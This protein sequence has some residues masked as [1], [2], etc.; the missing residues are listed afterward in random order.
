MNTRFPLFLLLVLSLKLANAATYYVDASVGNDTWSGNQA[1]PLGS[2]STDGP[3]QS[4]AKVSAGILAPGDSVLL[5]CGEIWNET[6]TLQSSGTAVSPIAI[7]AYP[8]ACTNKP[9]IS[10]ST[11]IPAHNW[12]QD[13]G[14]IYK[15]SSAIDLITFG[16]FESGLG[17]WA[18]WSPNNN[19]IMNLSTSCAS[20]GNTCMSFTA[21]SGNSIVSSNNFTLYGKQS[22]TA[23]FTWKFPAGIPIRVILRR[24]A[25]PWNT[26]GLDTYITGTGTWQTLTVPFIA[27]AGL[28]NAR[29]DFE[30]PAGRNISLDNVKISAVLADVAGVFDS[31]KAISVAHHPNRGY[32]PLKSDSL[33]YAIAEDADKVNLTYGVIGSTYL[34][35]GADLSATVHPAITAGT[36]IRVRTN[37]WNISDRKI[38]S[39][40]GSRFYFDSPTTYTVEKD[41]GYF[42]YGQRWMLD[43]PGEWHYDAATKTVYVWMPDSAAPGTRVVVGQRATGIEASNLSHIRI[44]GL[45]IQHVGTGVLMPDAINIVLSNMSISDTLGTGIDAVRSTDSGVESSQ[46][47]RTTGDA[48][49]AAKAD[50]SSIRFHA[51]DNL[52]MDS[53]SQ[54]KNGIITSLPVPARAAIEAGSDADIRGNSIYGTGYIGIRPLGSSLVSGNHI[55]NA[56]LILDDCGAIYTAGQNNN[57]IIEN[58]TVLHVP[59]GLPGRPANQSSQSQGIYLDSLCAGV[60]IRGNTV[61]DADSGIQL[62]SATNNHIENNT[63]YGNRRHQI[64]MHEGTTLVDAEG[65]MSG[66]HVLGNRLFSTLATTAIG[67][68][69]DLPKDN[70][71][72]FSSYDGNQF[73]TLLSPTMSSETWP[74]GGSDYT[75]PEWQTAVTDTGLPRNL[76]PTGSEV[77]SASIGYAAFRTAGINIVPNGNLGSGKAGWTAWN[78]TAPYGQ[79][80]LEPCTP[81]S[82]CLSYTAGASE[83]LVSS[84]NFSVQKDQWYKVSFDLKTG[85]NGQS[86]LV[87]A[88]RGGG[89]SNGYE[90]LMGAAI[91]FTGSVSWQR[92][93]FI[94]KATKTINANDPVTLDLG[95]R[96]DFTRILSGQDFSVANL[97]AVPIS[98]VE[99]TFRSHIL[100]NPTDTN[101]A[102]NCPDGSDAV[103]CSEYVR[104]TDSQIVT[105]PYDLPPH[106]SEIIYSRDI[107]LI[108]G[109][110]DG[111]PDYQDSC[112]GTGVLQAVN[113]IG[114]TL[115]QH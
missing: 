45:A 81:A 30:V 79:I 83:G 17:N 53:S 106:G 85:T 44:E 104:F 67:H 5:K 55:E 50:S 2:P 75:L 97:E 111:I 54:T 112:S 36:G 40:S 109:D 73:F 32:D 47:I 37:A 93:G 31:G 48:I 82:Q 43:E 78:L 108:D 57:S 19:A 69:T 72:R 74:G 62:Y 51:Y 88:R 52:I 34:T 114:C 113:A 86:V 80:V 103:L 96:I 12:I 15:L 21:G 26:V 8:Y 107:N 6:L 14:N 49:S 39:V 110:G 29:L 71:D 101:L 42:L 98:S 46:I 63:L 27:T 9:L 92:Y 35:T 91:N 4:L 7:G 58:N 3:W 70:T 38:A 13:T 65:D 41:W 59:G 25:A 100:I 94:F 77:N 11:A 68:L 95:A 16:T 33:Y 18:N 115:G 1:S 76:E 84:P 24:G 20:T 90:F 99:T 28:T 105:W 23:S 56:C 102:L 89:G 22:Y 87:M 10:G 60:T 61:V 64:W 66:N